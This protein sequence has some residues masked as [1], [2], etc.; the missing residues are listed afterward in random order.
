MRLQ[1]ILDAMEPGVE[2]TIRDLSPRITWRIKA[3]SWDDFPPAQKFFASGET[4]A[5]VFH[6]VKRGQ[7]H[8]DE[9]EGVL[10]FIKLD[11]KYDPSWLK[12]V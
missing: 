3:D 6:M 2:Y 1:E 9:R 7:V 4:M 12:S 8:M 11:D 10:Y 5:H